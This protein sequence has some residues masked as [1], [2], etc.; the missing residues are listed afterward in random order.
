MNREEKVEWLKIQIEADEQVCKDA[1]MEQ[2]RIRKQIHDLWQ[3]EEEINQQKQRIFSRQHD[4][5]EEL[6]KL[7]GLQG[8]I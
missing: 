2:R 7:L 4:H 8:L 5:K 1:S 3:E 6:K